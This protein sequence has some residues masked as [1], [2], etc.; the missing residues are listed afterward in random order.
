M[1]DDLLE[2]L[3]CPTCRSELSSVATRGSAI[4]QLWCPHC[5]QTTLVRDGI[6]RFV[7]QGDL[8]QRG[9][10]TAARTQSSFGYEWTHFNDWTKS[11]ATNFNDYFGN[12]DL[13]WL[14]GRTV[15]DAGCGMGRHARQTALFAKTVIAVDFSIAID[16]AARNVSDRPNVHCVQADL[17]CLPVPDQA[18][19]FVYSLGVLHHLDDTL[20]ALRELVRVLKPGGRLRLYLYWKRDGLAGLLLT[21]VTLAR[22]VTTR[23]PFAVLR[24]LCLVLSVGLFIGVVLPYRLLLKLGV[25]VNSSWPLSVYTKYPFTILYNDQF[26]RFSAPLE[27][28]Y[29][30]ADVRALFEAAGLTG[31]R[32]HACFGW[33][34]DGVKP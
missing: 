25:S 21:L 30:E 10:S 14:R 1:R 11:G 22:L 5:G 33:I 18:C 15:L 24:W 20:G 3:C 26:D 28:R 32:V 12:F 7:K 2:F 23:L 31:V 16:Q 6:P 29:N 34:A 9:S 19:D 13:E 17:I 8:G 27:K 4:D